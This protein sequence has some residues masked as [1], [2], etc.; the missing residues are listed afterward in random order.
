MQEAL[1]GNEGFYRQ[2]RGPSS[3]FRTS[4]HASAQFAAALTKLVAQVADGMGGRDGV[5][6]ID[7][8]AGE[9]ELLTQILEQLPPPVRHRVRPVAV[10]MRSR[11]PAVADEIH[12]TSELPSDIFGFVIANEWLDNIPL[13]VTA[14][15]KR[16]VR[17]VLVDP[18]TG[19]EQLGEPVGADEADWMARWWP[20]T[21]ASIGDRAE[22]GLSRDIAWRDL[23]SR[24]RQG[25]AV[26]VDYGHELRSRAAGGFAAG[27]LTGFRDGRMVDPVPDGSCDITAHVAFDSCAAA[28]AP[29]ES[30]FDTTVLTSQRSALKLLGV[31]G[32]RPPIQRA[33][34]DPIG[35]AKALADSSQAGELLDP[36]GLGGFYW[37][38]QTR[39]VPV[40][41]A[42]EGL[43]RFGEGRSPR[44]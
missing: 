40:P 23:T 7:V 37:L 36:A 2:G 27:T 33:R 8:G 17:E 15:D 22:V 35:Y 31:D 41:P 13:N 9:G 14:R 25:V 11:P 16:D 38:V 39:A 6:L 29:A 1:Y 30:E 18:E 24:L 32:A 28:A 20:L 3:H 19:H 10:E 12:W 21:D 26:A 44:P 4:V 43:T 34:Q 5:D 42:I